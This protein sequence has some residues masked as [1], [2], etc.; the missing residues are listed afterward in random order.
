MIPGLDVPVLALAG[1][2]AV[3]G[4]VNGALKWAF[5]KIFQAAFGGGSCPVPAEAAPDPGLPDPSLD[6]VNA[7]LRVQGKL[8]QNDSQRFNELGVSQFTPANQGFNIPGGGEY[9]WNF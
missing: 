7:S 9:G 5:R 2:G 3:V 4:A 6:A 8:L 1:A